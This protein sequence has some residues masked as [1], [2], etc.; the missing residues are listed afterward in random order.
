MTTFNL[1]AV[2]VDTVR[3]H[4]SPDPG[5][6]AE[7]VLDAIPRSAYRLA[8]RL[9]LRAYVREIIRA[10]RLHTERPA[11]EPPSPVTSTRA[12][13]SWKQDAMALAWQQQR[14]H[15]GDSRWEF[16]PDCTYDDLMVAAQER[17]DKA[18]ANLREAER[19]ETCASL[20]HRHGVAKLGDVPADEVAAALGGGA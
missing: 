6:L 20:I 5:D 1:H 17:R 14:I 3:N 16:L 9:L 18:K 10:H 19:Y 2:A 7:A 4:P 8:L 13:R 11:S 15:V 12:A